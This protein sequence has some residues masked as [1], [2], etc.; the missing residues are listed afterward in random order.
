MATKAGPD[1]SVIIKDLAKQI[2]AVGIE[3]GYHLAP[4]AASDPQI[5]KIERL[6]IQAGRETAE[7]ATRLRARAE[8]DKPLPLFDRVENPPPV[9]VPPPV[10]AEQP[11]PVGDVVKPATTTRSLTLAEKIE[12]AK[13]KPAT[14]AKPGK[15]GKRQCYLAHA[16][17]LPLVRIYRGTPELCRE[18]LAEHGIDVERHGIT[19]TLRNN[20]HQLLKIP[21]L[22][23]MPKGR[24]AEAIA[25][26]QAPEP[27]TQPSRLEGREKFVRKTF[28]ATHVPTKT[29]LFTLVDTNVF[30]AREFVARMV[31][32]DVRGDIRVDVACEGDGVGLPDFVDFNADAWAAT[33]RAPEPG[34]DEP[35]IITFVAVHTQTGKQLFTARSSSVEEVVE[36]CGVCL[37]DDQIA[38]LTIR[39]WQ[40]DE[41]DLPD[42]EEFNLDD[43]PNPAA[44]DRLQRNHV[45]LIYFNGHCGYRSELP[46]REEIQ[47]HL[48]SVGLVDH[49]SHTL[50]EQIKPKESLDLYPTLEKAPA[51]HVEGT[52]SLSLVRPTG[53]VM[54][55]EDDEPVTPEPKPKPK[56][57]RR[58]A[59]KA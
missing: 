51:S 56:R 19:L 52:F 4:I 44:M 12:A 9:I 10:V 46:T 32:A 39:P 57:T 49:R 33:L 34:A 26:L 7:L 17:S 47:K 59:V 25:R 37:T 1:R 20:S 18:Q 38:E 30:E 42:W 36:Y 40:D 29:D 35:P 11:P 21:A 13:E 14:T 50:F 45:W 41:A 23:D 48:D 24:L 55:V 2:A 5:G 8:A 3:F 15:L 31:P 22:T 6:L 28:I 43:W 53:P 58:K 27:A 54:V 16:G